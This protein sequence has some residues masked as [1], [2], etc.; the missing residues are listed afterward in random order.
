MHPKIYVKWDL[1]PEVI[2]ENLSS[3]L[4]KTALG[5]HQ[6]TWAEPGSSEVHLELQG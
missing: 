5:N 4:P 2:L 1:P 6:G 3:N